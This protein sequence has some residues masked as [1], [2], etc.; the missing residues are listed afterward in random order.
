[1][2]METYFEDVERLALS[3]FLGALVGLERELKGKEAGL[4]TIMLV[5]LGSALFTIVSYRMSYQLTGR[6]E[7]YTRIASYIV[8]GIGFLCAGLIF[9]SDNGVQGLTTATSVWAVTAIGMAAGCGL[10]IIALAATALCITILLFINVFERYLEKIKL[11]RTYY[12]KTRERITE[13]IL[14][15]DYFSDSHLVL[16]KTEAMRDNDLNVFRIN[17]RGS[18]SRHDVL[19]NRLLINTD[20]I[21]LRY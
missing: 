17:V 6:L 13:A 20:I 18:K 10:Y 5:S 16:L 15:Q 8:S 9:K 2:V 19:V 11:N 3:A 21:T 12:L 4:R 1:M 7:D 14:L